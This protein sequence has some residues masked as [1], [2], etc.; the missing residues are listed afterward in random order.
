MCTRRFSADFCVFFFWRQHA[1]NDKTLH[2]GEIPWEHKILSSVQVFSSKNGKIQ[3]GTLTR[4]GQKKIDY[5]HSKGF[6]V[7]FKRNFPIG[8]VDRRVLSER[9][10][11]KEGERR[12]R[13]LWTSWPLEP[14]FFPLALCSSKIQFRK[15]LWSDFSKNSQNGILWKE[16]F[17]K[18][19]WY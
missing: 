10:F 19:K 2:N 1:I 13:P 15:N 12:V 18:L 14:K 6:K 8:T 16:K 3:N 9:R 11:C 17:K 5:R 4:F 7:L